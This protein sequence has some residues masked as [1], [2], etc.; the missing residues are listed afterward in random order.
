MRFRL[1]S[2]LRRIYSFYYSLNFIK[3]REA[4]FINTQETP[5]NNWI[6]LTMARDSS[7]IP[8]QIRLVS[9]ESTGGNPKKFRRDS[10]TLSNKS[11]HVRAERRSSLMSLFSK[12]EKSDAESTPNFQDKKHLELFKSG[13]FQ[14]YLKEHNVLT[15]AGLQVIFQQF[16][17]DRNIAESERRKNTNE[18]VG[19]DEPV[20]RRKSS[21]DS[22]LSIAGRCTTPAYKR[23]STSNGSEQYGSEN[24]LDESIWSIDDSYRR[25]YMSVIR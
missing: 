11:E 5:S 20:H 9:D 13:E 3:Q 22:L 16:L 21:G 23:R 1:R 2:L 18:R 8:I 15:T 14:A 6:I 25:D 10:S 4:P 17:H 24:S 19:A 12:A 7:F